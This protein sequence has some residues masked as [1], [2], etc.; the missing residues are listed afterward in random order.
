MR[1]GVGLCFRSLPGRGWSLPPSRGSV[2]AW[3]WCPWPGRRLPAAHVP[4]NLAGPR[5]GPTSCPSGHL[6]GACGPISPALPGGWLC[7]GAGAAALG[8]PGDQRREALAASPAGPGG[9]SQAAEAGPPLGVPVGDVR[10]AGV[11][12]RC[13]CVRPAQ[14]GPGGRALRGPVLRPL[15]RAPSALR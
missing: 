8:A 5:S 15:A 9:W 11:S 14:A 1:T 2:C 10:Q 13:R 3:R 6:V 7:P 4:V 12:D